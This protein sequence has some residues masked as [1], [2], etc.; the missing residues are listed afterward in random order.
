[1]LVSSLHGFSQLVIVAGKVEFVDILAGSLPIG[2][3]VVG[4]Q[5]R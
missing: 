2:Q 3:D 5:M 4:G 1:M